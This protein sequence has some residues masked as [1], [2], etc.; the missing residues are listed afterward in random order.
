MSD[1]DVAK[2]LLSINAKY[3]EDIE[4]HFGVRNIIDQQF[5]HKTLTYF[6]I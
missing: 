6:L 3:P 1:V 2:L 4:E 5:E